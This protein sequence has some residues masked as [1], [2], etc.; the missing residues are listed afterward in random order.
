MQVQADEMITYQYQFDP[1]G[2]N[3]E[4]YMKIIQHS[5][6]LADETL[7]FRDNFENVLSKVDLQTN[8]RKHLN[9]SYFPCVSPSEFRRPQAED[10]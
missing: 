2:G 9:F 5:V 7:T 6:V 10:V 3:S 8:C 1:G 4:K